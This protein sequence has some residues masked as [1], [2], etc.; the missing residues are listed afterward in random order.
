MERRHSHSGAGARCRTI[1][2]GGR[3]P[4]E[5]RA[6]RG[7]RRQPD[8]LGRDRSG[9]ARHDL[10]RH[11]RWRSAHRRRRDDLES[12]L[13]DGTRTS[14]SRHTACSTPVPASL[15]AWTAARP[16]RTRRSPSRSR[17]STRSLS[18]RPSPYFMYAAGQP[19]R[20]D[21]YLCSLFHVPCGSAIY[22]GSGGGDFRN[23]GFR[24]GGRI[25]TLAPAPGSYLV[26]YAVQHQQTT[27]GS[28][29]IPAFLVTRDGGISWTAKP[30][31]LL[32]DDPWS[33]AVSPANSD[34]VFALIRRRQTGASELYLTRDGGTSCTCRRQP[35]VSR[36]GD[37]ARTG[38][39]RSRVGGDGTGRVP[40]GGL[41]RHLDP[42]ERR[43]SR[44][45]GGGHRRAPVRSAYP[46]RGDRRPPLPEPGFGESWRPIL[47]ASSGCASATSLCL[48]GVFRVDAFWRVP[49]LGTSGSARP[50][51]LTANSGAFWFFQPSNLEV[52]LK[53]LDGGRHQSATTGSTTARCRTSST[54][55]R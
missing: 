24:V 16:G 1:R 47:S 39:L 34:D 31:Q 46:V 32:Y 11:R 50:V 36:H 17:V 40:L 54:R 29:Q 15:E 5:R 53:V 38:Q 22:R 35:S 43:P 33:L 48:A 45:R 26:A 6:R 41:R 18:T 19:S 49:G 23:R 4:A 8:H 7:D 13:G 28:P 52:V 42:P 51:P 55:S 37:R 30:S 21:Q 14:S 3:P 2:R 9:L 25:S 10:R 20:A 27:A 44:R 12:R